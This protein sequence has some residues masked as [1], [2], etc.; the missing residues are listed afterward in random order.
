MYDNSNELL[1][2]NM[3]IY[4]FQHIYFTNSNTFILRIKIRIILICAI[5]KSERIACILI[6]LLLM[7]KTRKMNVLLNYKQ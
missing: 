6:N 7:L 4:E 3:Y 1:K 2:I 5:F